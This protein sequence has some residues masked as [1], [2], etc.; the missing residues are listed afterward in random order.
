MNILLSI[1][2]IFSS[3]IFSFEK[4]S[5]V[6]ANPFSFQD[7]I[8]DLDNQQEQE[9]YGI[10]RLPDNFNKTQKIPL[11]IL[12]GRDTEG[13]AEIFAAALQ[14][15]GRAIVVGTRTDGNIESVHLIPLLDGSRIFVSS[16]SYKTVSGLSV[17]LFGIEPNIRVSIDWDSVTPMKDPVINS[18]LLTLR[19]E[20]ENEK[21]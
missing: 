3:F 4:I 11:I 12:I 10:L 9:V 15:A 5:F 6:S 13:R 8:T 7:I 19:R 17:G 20:K 1:I 14:S 2:V 18:A 16:T 21:Y